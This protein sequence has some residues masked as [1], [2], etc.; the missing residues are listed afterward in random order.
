M[1]GELYIEADDEKDAIK[2][3]YD[4]SVGLPSE[5]HYINDSFSVCEDAVKPVSIDDVF[6]EPDF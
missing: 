2:K 3:A 1:Y 4:S 5:R 6:C